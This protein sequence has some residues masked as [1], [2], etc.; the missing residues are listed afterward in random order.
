MPVLLFQTQGIFIFV[1]LEL[2]HSQI[3]NFPNNINCNAQ[4][5]FSLQL[6]N[7]LPTPLL[8][9]R[10]KHCN[11]RAYLA[12]LPL[13]LP[14]FFSIWQA[15]QHVACKLHRL[16]PVPRLDHEPE[17]YGALSNQ[18]LMRDLCTLQDFGP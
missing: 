18:A 5:P 2:C 16:N 8:E 13:Q 1:S 17:V 12:L 4:I 9:I 15:F 10:E 7:Q 11:F 3:C 6:K 14:F